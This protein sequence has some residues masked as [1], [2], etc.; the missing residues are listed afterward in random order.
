MKTMS[1]LASVILLSVAAAQQPEKPIAKGMIYGTVVDQDGE[2]AREVGLTAYPIGVPLG[3][4][5]PHTKTDRNGKF[6]F[7][8]IPWWGRYTVSA[9]DEDAGYSLFS[10]GLNDPK[11]T[12]EV[13][14]SP[15]QPEAE[16]NLFLPPKAGFLEIHLTNRKT[17]EVIGAVLVTVMSSENPE[18]LKSSISCP[19]A[20]VIL[21]PPNRD[22]LLHV[23][24]WGFSR[25]GEECWN[26]NA[27]PCPLSQ[28]A[29]IGCSTR[30]TD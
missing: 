23:T 2:P 5:L 20:H 19:S 26:R 27:H 11:S 24:S 14:L 29:Q 9:E 12:K 28:P 17:G 21:L 6:R 22:V 8:S 1:V 18:R 30:T 10:T 15:K 16:F 7:D 25:V 4:R 3:T 13:T